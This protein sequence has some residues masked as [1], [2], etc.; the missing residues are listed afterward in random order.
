MVL[1]ELICTDNTVDIYSVPEKV[2]IH[3]K[4]K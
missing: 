4:K 2:V 3:L 1:F